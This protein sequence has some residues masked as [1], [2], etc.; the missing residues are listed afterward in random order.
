MS[1]DA[2]ARPAS[3]IDFSNNIKVIPDVFPACGVDTNDVVAVGASD[4]KELVTV[5][6]TCP[7][8]VTREVTDADWF[9]H[10]WT[11]ACRESAEEIRSEI[12]FGEQTYLAR[13][14]KSKASDKKR[15]KKVSNI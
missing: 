6:M 5:V 14:E 7:E 8:A 13:K 10:A 12:A 2:H 4:E 15:D 11:A 9:A 1:Q 3:F